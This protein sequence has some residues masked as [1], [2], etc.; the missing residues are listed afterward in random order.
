MEMCVHSLGFL[1][2]RCFIYSHVFHMKMFVS[3]IDIGLHTQKFPIHPISGSSSQD[4]EH[5][6]S[7][8]VNTYLLL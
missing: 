8:I 2:V 4:M 1:V 3:V 5:W 6:R 7:L